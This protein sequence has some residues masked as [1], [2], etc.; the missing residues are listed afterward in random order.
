I[1]H[2]IMFAI[3]CAVAL[4]AELKDH[5]LQ[6]SMDRCGFSETN[7]V[8]IDDLSKT[9]NTPSKVGNNSDSTLSPFANKKPYECKVLLQELCKKTGSADIDC[10]HFA[11]AD[12][13]SLEDSTLLVVVKPTENETLPPVRVAFE[14]IELRLHSEAT[15]QTKPSADQDSTKNTKDG[16]STGYQLHVPDP[17]KFLPPELRREM[18][19][20][21]GQRILLATRDLEKNFVGEVVWCKGGPSR[22]VRELLGDEKSPPFRPK[23]AGST[24]T[25]ASIEKTQQGKH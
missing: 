3:C 21:N 5:I 18:L 22:I 8:F 12:G 23:K 24:Q 17:A 2:A 10:D 16:K 13:Q 19:L 1:D 15:R 6:L 14:V 7:L 25:D 4:S 20:D 9:Y 11:V